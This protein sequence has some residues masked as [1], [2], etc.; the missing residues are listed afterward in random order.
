MHI[1]EYKNA[2]A[3]KVYCYIAECIWDKAHKKYINPRVPIGHLE[4]QPS[5]F[6]PNRTFASL[7]QSDMKDQTATG[8]RERDIIATV[9][10]KYGNGSDFLLAT[11]P[12]GTNA[13]TAKAVFSGPYIVFGGIT[14]RYNIDTMLRKSFGEDD[15]QEILSL[16]WFLAC[17]RCMA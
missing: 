13:P 11:E 7:L 4:G 6:V 5:R 16:A 10:S 3:R 15:A 8:I 2:R 17:Q 12:G 14:S 1:I 9:N